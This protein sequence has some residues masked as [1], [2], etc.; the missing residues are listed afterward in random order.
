MKSRTF[1]RYLF[2][3][4]YRHRKKIT[5]TFPKTPVLY[6]QIMQEYSSRWFHKRA[7]IHSDSNIC[8][9]YFLRFSNKSLNNSWMSHLGLPEGGFQIFRYISFRSL[10]IYTFGIGEYV[11][12]KMIT[13]I[14]ICI[15]AIYSIL[16]THDLSWNAFSFVHMYKNGTQWRN[17]LIPAKVYLNS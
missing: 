4:Q 5:H 6:I 15:F 12:T 3:P 9:P 8:R 17:N 14:F 2:F 1:F 11:F 10:K 13:V 16:L 7:A